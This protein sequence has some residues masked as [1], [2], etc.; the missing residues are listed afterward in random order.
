MRWSRKRRLAVL[1]IIFSVALYAVIQSPR[2]DLARLHVL[3]DSG[4]KLSPGDSATTVIQRIGRPDRIGTGEVVDA[5]G[6]ATSTTTWMYMTRYDWDG[7]R[8]RW[9]R[10]S[11][12]PYWCSRIWPAK[13]PSVDDV[14]IIH[15]VD[16]VIFA[17]SR[18]D[19]DEGLL[20][21]TR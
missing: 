2:A 5:T 10:Q 12:I 4:A 11:L 17:S 14:L 20:F 8:T 15:L 6:E 1:A 19:I 9:N 18:E 7:I 21:R 13:T 3:H 16:D